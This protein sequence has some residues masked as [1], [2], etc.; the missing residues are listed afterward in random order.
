MVDAFGKPRKITE[1]AFEI[2]LQLAPVAADIGAQAQVLF[3]RQIGEG[4]APIWHMGDAEPRDVL[5][6][7]R[8]Q[9]ASRIFECAFAPDHCTD[10]AQCRRLAGPIGAKQR[11]DAPILD[12]KVH[13]VKRF[14]GSIKG[15]E[16]DGAQ[17]RAHAALPQVCADDVGMCAH[18]V[19]RPVGN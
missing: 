7:A 4:A 5:W 1:D 19:G 14:D 12:F 13:A 17:N 8:V 11:S 16:A 18:F 10:G 2:S 6:R 9:G 15:L 3:D